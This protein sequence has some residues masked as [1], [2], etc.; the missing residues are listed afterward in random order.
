MSEIKLE[1][2]QAEK[3]PDM[4]KEINGVT[5]VVRAHFREGA[6]ETMEQKIKRMLRTE[7]ASM[8][9]AV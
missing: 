9:F 5:Y 1:V 6:G 7:V 2:K 3:G 8:N 4:I